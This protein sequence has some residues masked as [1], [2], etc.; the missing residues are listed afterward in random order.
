LLAGLVVVLQLT[1]AILPGEIVF[2][3]AN[4]VAAIA[5]AHFQHKTWPDETFLIESKHQIAFLVVLHVFHHHLRTP[6]VVGCGLELSRV[7]R[8][9]FGWVF[10]DLGERELVH[11]V[12]SIDD[13]VGLRWQLV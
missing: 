9:E 2:K 8:L 12:E 3:E 6:A 10:V 5:V 4:F 13:G 11:L 7:G 1:N